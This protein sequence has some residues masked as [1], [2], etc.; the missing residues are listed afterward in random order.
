MM[1]GPHV[2]LTLHERRGG[3]PF[4]GK[5]PGWQT[6]VTFSVLVGVLRHEP[7]PSLNAGHE[8]AGGDKRDAHAL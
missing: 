6:P 3:A 5:Y 1:I 8:F 2:M 7:A 4:V